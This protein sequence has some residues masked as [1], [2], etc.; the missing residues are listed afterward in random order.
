MKNYTKQEIV[1]FEKRYRTNFVNSLWGFKSVNLVGTISA[2]G[3]TNLAI[4]SQV[5]HLGASP[6]LVGLIVR[7]AET[8]RHT[9]TYM[10]EVGDFTLNHLHK[11][12]IRQGHQTSARY[13][14]GRSEF[15]ATGL[16]PIWSDE[17][18]SPYVKE[19]RMRIGCKYVDEMTIK[20]NGT[21]LVVGSVEEVW[22]DEE[23]VQKDGFIN[24]ES[25]GTITCSNLDSYHET[26]K[27]TRLSYAKPDQPLT[28]L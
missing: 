13:A 3:F 1:E 21:I 5:V 12:I 27:L 22:V 10:K 6:A 4:F 23:A 2:E 17:I 9:Y 11:D 19:S 28:E 26:K 8:D 18:K 24:L 7:P 16:S 15:E 25:I 14:K 20:Q